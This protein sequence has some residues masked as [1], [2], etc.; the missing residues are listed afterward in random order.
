MN[1]GAGGPPARVSSAVSAPLREN[2]VCGFPS[3]STFEPA[4][5][6]W[7]GATPPGS[8]S[9][10]DRQS[11]G[12]STAGYTPG[13][14][15]R[16]GPAG[17]PCPLRVGDGRGGA[18]KSSV[19]RDS[20]CGWGKGALSVGGSPA[21]RAV[22]DATRTP[23]RS[24]GFVDPGCFSAVSAPLREN[25]VCG[26]A[27]LSAIEPA[28]RSWEGATPPGSVSSWVRHSG[29][30]ATAGY[31][32]GRLRRPGPAGCR[33]LR[34][35]STGGPP[36]TPGFGASLPRLF[37]EGAEGFEDRLDQGASADP[38]PGFPDQAGTDGEVLA[39]E[40]ELQTAQ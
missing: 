10:W 24:A 11:G 39:V 15:R 25:P 19:G 4:G 40:F 1:G 38:D 32:P 37:A 36:D 14:L 12:R 5:R 8:V 16:P 13:R 29:G 34:R 28:G 20:R 26:F 2:P 31:T 35:G 21:S 7:E 3:L 30:R 6:G 22:A 9:S 18:E 33:R 23:G 17:C 27:S